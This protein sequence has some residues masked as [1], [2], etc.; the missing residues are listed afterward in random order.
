[1]KIEFPSQ[2]SFRHLL[3]IKK[4]VYFP[5]IT[6]VVVSALLVFVIIPTF[7]NLTLLRSEISRRKEIQRGLEM[8][9]EILRG[10]DEARLLEQVETLE[11]AIPSRKDVFLLL[12]SLNG[13]AS[14]TGVALGS[15]SLSPG[16]LATGAAT[17]SATSQPDRPAETGSGRA[18][19]SS[20]LA[21]IEVGIEVLGPFE[22][23]QMFLSG[24][25]HVVPLMRL[26]SVD[27]A[28]ATLETPVFA[29]TS[30]A[31]PLVSDI[32][33]NAIL[34]MFYAPLPTE[35]GAVTDPIE[36][37]SETEQGVYEQLLSFTSFPASSSANI[38]TGREDV[39]APF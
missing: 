22:G 2:I 10:L 32:T 13:L 31:F 4:Y 25:E 1:M 29:S 35:L 21:S 3:Q 12:T 20:Q 9:I 19:A 14:Q 7:R 38:P 15:F 6:L 5:L 26:T 11:K 16:S 39:F 34:G 30:S 17:G 27:L 36:T 8:K 23:V 28:P 37:P 18:A 24:L 33:A